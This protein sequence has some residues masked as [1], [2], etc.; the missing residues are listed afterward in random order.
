MV[1]VRSESWIIGKGEKKRFRAFETS[2]YSKMLKA[3]GREKITNQDVLRRAQEDR[4][5]V[6]KL[7]F[8]RDKLIGHSLQHSGLVKRIVE[9]K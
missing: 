4:S 3:N 7:K 8:R 2:C 1:S 5:F 6:R 9:G